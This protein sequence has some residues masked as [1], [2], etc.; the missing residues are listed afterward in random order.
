MEISAVITSMYFDSYFRLQYL[1]TRVAELS[2][3]MS[4]TTF[5]DFI[6]QLF[7]FP[8]RGT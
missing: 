2:C 4:G 5:L 3:V 1:K 8:N 7:A 6:H